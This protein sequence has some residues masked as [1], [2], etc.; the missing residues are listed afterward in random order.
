MNIK[1]SFLVALAA[2]TAVTSV[3][4]L[5]VSASSL[6]E[7]AEVVVINVDGGEE[8][9]A[10][11]TL[12]GGAGKKLYV[13]A[14]LPAAAPAGEYAFHVAVVADKDTEDAFDAVVSSNVKDVFE[15]TIRDAEGNAVEFFKNVKVSIA[16]NLSSLSAKTTA[17]GAKDSLL[18]TT[19]NVFY[20]KAFSVDGVTFAD[21]GADAEED[22]ITFTTEG[23]TKFVLAHVENE[24]SEESSKEP[25]SDASKEQPSTPSIPTPSDPVTPTGDNTAATTAVFAVM[26][27][28]AL[29]AVLAATKM[30]KT[31]K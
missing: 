11:A 22:V 9:Q 6:G 4:A 23:Y 18:T 19:A 24:I 29:G 26:G 8:T 2:V 15:L 25:V 14:T 20:N 21:L 12:D 5:T 27:A 16:L 30:K 13:K 17:A 7:S 31:S 3:S 28:V 10:I 1:K